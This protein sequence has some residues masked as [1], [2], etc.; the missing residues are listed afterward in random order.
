MSVEGERYE[1]EIEKIVAGGDGLARVD[2]RA[3]F[4]PFSAPGDRLVV[5]VDEKSRDFDRASIQRVV[6]GGPNRVTPRCGHF[7]V[8]GGCNLQHISLEAQQ[9]ARADIIRESL[10]RLGRIA[11]D[12]VVAPIEEGDGWR[13]RTRVR[14]VGDLS[15]RAAYRARGAHDAVTIRE[16]PVVTGDLEKA[17]VEARIS[18]ETTLVDT[19]M[20]VHASPPESFAMAR[21][22]GREI[23]FD[24][25]GFFQGNL[26]RTEALARWL[27]GRFEARFSGGDKP[28]L[29]D[30][31]GG[32][33]LWAAAVRDLVSSVTVI[34]S[35]ERTAAFAKENVANARVLTQPAE[36]VA[37]KVF[38]QSD[39][40]VLDPPRVGLH[41]AVVD[42]LLDALPGYVVYVSCYPA[43]FARDT[44]RLAQAYRLVTIQPFDFYPQ[45][46]HVELAAVFVPNGDDSAGDTG[47]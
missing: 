1:V 41:R 36:R 22:A 9:V 40:V 10:D 27:R 46:D 14:V 15:G 3:V 28:R 24:P 2:G 33:G 18:G 35:D 29:V 30:V 25:G 37:A 43:S 7:G 17:L 5:Q 39:L 47:A 4:V 32:V 12:D 42:A 11:A 8:C 31:Y 20:A 13:T 44:A 19:G 6:H 26:S 38:A 45:T 21:V 23:R 16:C 34:E